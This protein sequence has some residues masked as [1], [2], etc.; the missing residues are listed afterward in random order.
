MDH[1]TDPL[2]LRRPDK[3]GLVAFALTYGERALK[4]QLRQVLTLTS[5]LLRQRLD[6]ACGRKK[7]WPWISTLFLLAKT[8][9][10]PELLASWID[11]VNDRRMT[12]E[13]EEVPGGTSGTDHV[14]G[15]IGAIIED[16]LPT[17]NPK[18]QIT[19]I[20][21]L[22]EQLVSVRGMLVRCKPLVDYGTC[23]SDASPS[24]TMEH[25]T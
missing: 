1:G 10:D 11:Q 16:L 13:G 2:S 19:F 7:N 17:L 8:C 15:V 22:I 23:S 6:E 12:Q 4:G 24:S 9:L 21:N 20:H 3:R 14:I 18:Y 25:P 5:P